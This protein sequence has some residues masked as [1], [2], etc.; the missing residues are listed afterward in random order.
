MLACN[1][2]MMD[3]LGQLG[4]VRIVD[5]EAGTVEVEVPVPSVGVAPVLSELFRLAAGD[6]FAAVTQF[7]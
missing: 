4:P 5:R 7:A 1:R 6:D 2:E 3:L